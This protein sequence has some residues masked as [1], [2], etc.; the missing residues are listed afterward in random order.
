MMAYGPVLMSDMRD[1]LD[2]GRAGAHQPHNGGAR[3]GIVDGTG[4]HGVG[5]NVACSIEDIIAAGRL[6][7]REVARPTLVGRIPFPFLQRKT[8]LRR[9]AGAVGRTR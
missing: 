6:S 7:E 1:L 4:N 5:K 2:V 3:I 9:D 8:A